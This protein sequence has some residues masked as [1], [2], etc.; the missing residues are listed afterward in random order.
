M[1]LHTVTGTLNEHFII[2]FINNIRFRGA[3]TQP[4][5]KINGNCLWLPNKLVQGKTILYGQSTSVW[6]LMYR[7]RKPKRKTCLSKF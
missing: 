7:A 5:Q 4:Y 3:G 2:R 1:Y 6:G